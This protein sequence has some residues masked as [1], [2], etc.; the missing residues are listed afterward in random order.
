MCR[1]G[2]LKTVNIPKKVIYREIYPFYSNLFV[3]DLSISIIPDDFGSKGLL[4]LT[5]TL[6]VRKIQKLFN[7]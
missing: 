6:E 4:I 3:I 2:K 5:M 1:P 7:I